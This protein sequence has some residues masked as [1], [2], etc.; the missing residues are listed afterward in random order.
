MMVY[1]YWSND[2]GGELCFGGTCVGGRGNQSVMNGR[3]D[4]LSGEDPSYVKKITCTMISARHST[5][6]I[7]STST[8]H[9]REEMETIL[10]LS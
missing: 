5:H 10:K 6:S 8:Q 4:F 1:W 7:H 3:F 9:C 2:G